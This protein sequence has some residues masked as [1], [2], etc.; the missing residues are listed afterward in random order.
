MNLNEINDWDDERLNLK[1][2]ILRGIYSHGFENPSP[3]QK[4]GL[5]PMIKKNDETNLR[6]DILA[7]AQSGTGKT[8]CFVIGTL[9]IINFNINEIQALILAPT[10]ELANQIFKV[11]TDI[12][13]YCDITMQ[14]LVGGKPIDKDIQKLKKNPHVVIGTPGRVFDMIYKNY[15]NTN[16]LKLVICDEADEMLS[17]GFK[18]QIYN[19]LKYM[20]DNIQLGLFSATVPDS[21]HS[22]ID[23]FMNKN[24]SEIR[25]KNDM[26]TLQGIQQYYV[27]LNNDDNKF[28]TIK[29]IFGG[30]SISQCI[31]YCNTTKRVDQLY[32]AMKNEK[33]PVE[34]IHG[35]MSSEERNTVTKDFRSGSSRVLITSDL[36]ARG[37]DVQ[38]V[39][40]VINFDVPKNVNTYLHRIGRSGRWGR[41]G[42]AINFVTKF[43]SNKIKNFEEFYHTEITEMPADFTS[44]IG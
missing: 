24:Y 12:S 4:K 21:L 32:Y 7:Q 9:Q 10:H 39:S 19:I 34:R 5:L 2:E 18:E 27:N 29:D 44:H 17:F 6:N 35:K 28:E 15:L 16:N 14:L 33:Y 8:G 37:I 43:D 26:L 1:K 25:V 36:F 31:I 23:T 22:V 38:Q 41:K 11:M 13:K 30:L 3:I 40:I 42:V 20:P